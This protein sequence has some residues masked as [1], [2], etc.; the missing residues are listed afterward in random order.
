MNELADLRTMEG[1]LIHAKHVLDQALSPSW[2][3]IPKVIIKNCKGIVILTVA[4]AG[5]IFSG[6]VGTGVIIAHDQ[7]RGTW[8]P[9]SALG[10]GGVGFGL[11]AG[12]E[13]K[14]LLICVMD[15]GTLNTFACEHQVKIGSQVAATVG[16]LGREAD[17]SFNFSE[18]GGLGVTINYAFS[19]GAFAG[20]SLE[21]AV[22]NTRSKENE[23]FYGKPAKASE[24]LF[25]NAV[26][27]P[28]GKGVE[29]LHHRLCLLRDG[30]VM[31]HEHASQMEAGEI[32]YVVKEQ[33]GAGTG[34]TNP[35]PQD[36]TMQNVPPSA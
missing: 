29:E 18:R 16:P 36:P 25:D 30:K 17:A 2:A 15:D 21:T 12:A 11:M 14:D 23:R 7:V 24:I 13:V 32:A 8:S 31:I 6:N 26:E 20:I 28:K 9:P 3:G 5:F 35:L 1:I 19:K 27:I 33:S 34:Y 10:L 22:L 4:E